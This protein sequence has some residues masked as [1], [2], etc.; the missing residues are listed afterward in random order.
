MALLRSLFFQSEGLFLMAKCPGRPVFCV[1]YN[2]GLAGKQFFFPMISLHV[3]NFDLVGKVKYEVVN[4][5]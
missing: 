4:D 5:L 3:L 2:F 1:D